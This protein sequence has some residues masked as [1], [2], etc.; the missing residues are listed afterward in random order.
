MTLEVN[1]IGPG[2][3]DHLRKKEY[4]NLDEMQVVSIKQ[5]GEIDHGA[6]YAYK[7]QETYLDWSKNTLPRWV[8]LRLLDVK[9]TTIFHKDLVEFKIETTDSRIH[10]SVSGEIEIVNPNRIDISIERPS[11][12][13]GFIPIPRFIQQLAKGDRVM[14]HLL[15]SVEKE[16]RSCIA[17]SIE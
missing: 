16:V 10:F 15:Q 2:F 14:T 11:I 12:R 6:V 8:I 5:I 13:Y 3:M 7:M 4:T 9:N 17:L 1:E